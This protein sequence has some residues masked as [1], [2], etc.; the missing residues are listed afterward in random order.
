MPVFN[1]NRGEKRTAAAGDALDYVEGETTHPGDGTEGYWHSHLTF[2]NYDPEEAEE[3]RIPLF[4]GRAVEQDVKETP[5]QGHQPMT[6][7]EW[8]G[9]EE[10]EKIGRYWVV[11]EETSWTS[12][13]KHAQAT[14]YLIDQTDMVDAIKATPGSWCYDIFAQENMVSPTEDNISSLFEKEG[15]AARA[16]DLVNR[17]EKRIFQT[18]MAIFTQIKAFLRKG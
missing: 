9:L 5:A 17:M 12:C 6:M 10:H 3:D 14:S 15:D 7:R 11:D 13:L 1:H 8:E 16:R 4:P 18:S 2:K